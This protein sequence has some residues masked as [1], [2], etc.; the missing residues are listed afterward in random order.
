MESHQ[1]SKLYHSMTCTD[2]SDFI[3]LD[4]NEI[5]PLN[6]TVSE[7]SNLGSSDQDMIKYD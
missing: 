7:V 6:R 2:T 1:D 3:V 4:K 5:D